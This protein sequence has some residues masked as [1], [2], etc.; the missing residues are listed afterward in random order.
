LIPKFGDILM[1]RSVPGGLSLAA[2]AL[3][4][5]LA[6]CDSAGVDPGVPT[7]T[8]KADVPLDKISTDMVGRTAKDVAKANAKA[9]EEKA[10][11]PTTP[12]EE[13]K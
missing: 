8:T 7:D 10:K 5:V 3:S 6:G 9:A 11:A 4:L 13:K 2:A 12:V 1:K